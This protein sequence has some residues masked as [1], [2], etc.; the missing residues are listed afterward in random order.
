MLSGGQMLKITISPCHL[1]SPLALSFSQSDEA[2]LSLLLL[3]LLLAFYWDGT[4]RHRQIVMMT[5]QMMMRARK[6]ES[7]ND[8]RCRVSTKKKTHEKVSFFLLLEWHVPLAHYACG[9][10][11]F[12]FL[13]LLLRLLAH[14]FTWREEEEKKV[15]FLLFI[16]LYVGRSLFS[17]WLSLWEVTHR[18]IRVG[19][20][21][22]KR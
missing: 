16:H 13:L 12:L 2:C 19:L 1:A 20:N 3:L 4:L 5:Q 22:N 17:L 18:V 8:G 15:R 10:L 7:V 21:H 11:W 6:G 14:Y 9:R